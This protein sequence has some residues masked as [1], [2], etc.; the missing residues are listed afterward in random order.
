MLIFL[1]VASFLRKI[2]KP[3]DK[4]QLNFGKM[5]A[6]L[7]CLKLLRPINLETE[8]HLRCKE[9]FTW[10]ASRFVVRIHAE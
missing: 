9:A 1:K 5:A 7:I 10:A 6:I 3:T 2:R 8:Q 4:C